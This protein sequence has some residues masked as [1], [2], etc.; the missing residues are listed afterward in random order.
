MSGRGTKASRRWGVA[1]LLLSL[2]FA[3]H[4]ADEAL[5]DFLAVYNP[6]AAGVRERWPLLVLPTFT[7]GVWITLLLFA[8]ATLFVLSPLAFQG[9]RWMRP[10]SYAYAIVMLGNGF[11]HL[12]GSIYFGRV[13]PGSYSSPLLIAA[14]LFLLIVVAG[15]RSRV[16]AAS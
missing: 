5:N 12:L 11:M 16:A 14:A 8:L 15:G 6:I 1:W 10:I 7:F 9:G 13:L 2:A 4:I 3:V